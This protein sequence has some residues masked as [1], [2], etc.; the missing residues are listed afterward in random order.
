M[1]E[2][3]LRPPK[4]AAPDEGGFVLRRSSA[5]TQ[6]QKDITSV[7]SRFLR[8]MKNP[9]DGAA[10]MLLHA[11]PDEA[12]EAVNSA[13]NAIGG[14]GTFLGDKLGIK[15][16]TREEIDSMIAGSQKEFDEARLATT[17][18]TMESMHT[19]RKDV[20]VD[21]AGFVGE[22]LSPVNLA[23]GAGGAGMNLTKNAAVKLGLLGGIGAATQPLTSTESFAADKATQVG[24]GAATGATL[25]PLLMKATDSLG[26]YVSNKLASKTGKA[27]DISHEIQV[28]MER[29]GIDL[30]QIPESI[31]LE[32][33]DEVRKSL[34]SG[35][36]LDPAA[37]LRRIEFQR[38]G[39]PY[40]LGQVTRDPTQYSRELNLRGIQGVGEPIADR[41]SRQQDIISNKFR[42]AT[43]GTTEPYE[44]GA[45]LIKNLESKNLEMSDKVR[46]AYSDFR[47]STGRNLEVPLQ[48]LAQDYANTLKE[49]RDH[50][51]GAVRSR[52]EELGLLSGKQLKSMT[53][54]DAESVIKTINNN[55]DPR[56]PP[57][58]RALDELRSA[59]VK[60]I[61]EASDE[62]GDTLG[63]QLARTARATARERFKVI[64]QNPAFKAAINGKAAP[65]DFVKKFVIGGKADEVERLMTLVDPKNQEQMKLQ[66]MRFL[67]DK[68][69]GSNAAGDG[70]SR[71]A[72]F[73]DALKTIGG[74]K[75]TAVLGREQAEEMQALGRIMAY[76]QQ[77][78]AGSS[79][80]ESNT[81]SAVANILGKMNGTIKGAP[82]IKD[83]VIKPIESAKERAAVEN[84][85]TAKLPKKA[86]EL[87]PK[88]MRA[89]SRLAGSSAIIGGIAAG[90]SLK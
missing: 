32:L 48:G 22:V 79:V 47:K 40:T 4:T 34:R 73:N 21:V 53:L 82:Y 8:G 26:Q 25:G 27:V 20:P 19:G 16:M 13:A 86:S 65:D 81:A 11:L 28:A 45:S 55:Y 44:A 66:F 62:A 33:T 72:A 85:L 46:R 71:Q 57:L 24:L 23:A 68:A 89:L 69:F 58:S 77:R 87:D 63:A 43:Q 59:V 42:N 64:E 70:G 10:Q 12:I 3:T 90:E 17:P 15:G 41:L 83:F 50:I 37:V 61:D 39:V 54:E 29:D 67:Q 5:P 18:D 52:F 78:P 35:R 49:F 9:I 51:P 14:P 1:T 75:L 30:S 60:T 84:A 38:Q 36:N 7:P 56:N 80:N 2:F 76:I 88:V 74:R 31:R 6:R